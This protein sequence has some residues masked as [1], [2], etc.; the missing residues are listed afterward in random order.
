MKIYA[1]TGGVGA[2]KSAASRLFVERGIPVIDSDALGHEVIEPNGP[3]YQA[4]LDR[5]GPGIVKNGHIDRPSLGEIVFADPQALQDLNAI[6]HPAVIAETGRL[7][8]QYAAQGHNAIIIEA[9]LHAED[10]T[11]REPFEALILVDCPEDIRIERLAEHRGMPKE[12]ARARI[13]NQ[14]PPEKKKPLARW[15][16]QNYKSMVDLTR[17][18]DAIVPEL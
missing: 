5:F 18:V 14:T 4:V 8:A 1:L 12:E 10:G 3:A 2:G 11:L 6:V 7:S 9:A 15:V 13:A 16:I 17:Q